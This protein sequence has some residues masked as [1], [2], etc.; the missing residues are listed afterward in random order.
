MVYSLEHARYQLSMWYQKLLSANKR[1]K[2]LDVGCEIGH[3]L[4]FLRRRVMRT[5][6]VLT[7]PDR[8]FDS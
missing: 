1:A 6:G 3:F 2:T 7:S 8:K 5:M 4:Y